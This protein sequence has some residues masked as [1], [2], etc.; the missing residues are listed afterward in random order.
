MWWNSE[1]HMG[2]L[3]GK[4]IILFN[5]WVS[6]I[7]AHC[8]VTLATWNKCSIYSITIRTTKKLTQNSRSSWKNCLSSGTRSPVTD[9]I[10]CSFDQSSP[11][12]L[13]LLFFS[14]IHYISQWVS[15]LTT[16]SVCLLP[17]YLHRHSCQSHYLMLGQVQELPTWKPIQWLP[18]QPTP[19]SLT[20]C[21]LSSGSLNGLFL[22]PQGF[23][24]YGSNCSLFLLQIL[25]H[26]PSP[27]QMLLPHGKYCPTPRLDLIW[28]C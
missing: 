5:L 19:S 12:L 10:S 13:F 20:Q 9:T 6:Y 8:L 14:Y 28:C 1:W 26:C 15:L 11:K 3:R 23:W 24:A 7:G 27:A 21:V 25:S 17:H 16:S 18:P 4:H 22:L 2:K